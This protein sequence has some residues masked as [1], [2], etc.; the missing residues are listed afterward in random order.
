MQGAHVDTITVLT[1]DKVALRKVYDSSKGEAVLRGQATSYDV[2]IENV[3]NFDELCDIFAS[4]SKDKSSAIIR[5]ELRPEFLGSEVPNRNE[6]FSAH[7]R[8]WAIID[9]DGLSYEGDINDLDSI[10]ELVLSKLPIEFRNTAFWFNFSSNMGLKPGI[11]VHL[12]F[13]LS[14]PCTDTEMK[15]WL[16]ESEADDRVY[17]PNQLL[18]T[19]APVFPVDVEDPVKQRNGVYVNDGWLDTVCVPADLSEKAKHYSKIRTKRAREDAIKSR[20]S[21]I[22]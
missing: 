18:L 12:G 7:P 22:Y 17:A 20:S 21:R 9:I 11:R 19:C 14:R 2:S 13:W 6:Y 1:S 15:A 5:G 3:S 4:L 10:F 8:Q 16:K